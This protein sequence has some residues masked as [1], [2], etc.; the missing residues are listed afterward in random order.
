M[1]LHHGNWQRFWKILSNPA[2][3]VIVTIVVVMIATWYL[4][5]S[6]SPDILPPFGR[7]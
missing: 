1:D 4:I 5:E 6:G 2:L 3:E 7:R